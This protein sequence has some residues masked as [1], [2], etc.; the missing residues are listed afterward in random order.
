MEHAEKDGLTPPGRARSNVRTIGSNIVS[1]LTSDV[2]NRATPFFLYALVARYLSTFEFGQISLA[3]LL[4]YTFQVFAVAGLRTLITREVARD[5]TKT[6]KYLINGSIAVFASS[7]LSIIT[8][9]LFVWLM[10]YSADTA[11]AILLLAL[12]LVPYA[13]SN[14]CE[15]VFQAW[16]RMHYIAY[17]NAPSNIAKV[18]LTFL[19][20]TQGYGIYHLA[21]LLVLSYVVVLSIE[22]WLVLRYLTRPQAKLEPRFAL[23][24]VRET[25]PF[26]GIDSAIAIW[27]SL[28]V[29]LLSKMRNETDVGL[30]N[31]ASQLLVPSHLVFQ[32]LVLS[33]FPI[34]CRKFDSGLQNLKQIYEYL[35][36][37]LLAIALPAAVG[38]FFLAEPIL[39][40]LYGDQSFLHAAGVLRIMAWVLIPIALTRALGQVL[41]ASLREKVTLRIVIINTVISL[42]LG[43][44]LIKPFGIMGA[45]I[46]ALV[47]RI[48]DFFQHYVPVS[49]LLSDIAL[50]KVVWKSAVASLCMAV[51]LSVIGNSQGLWLTIP[52]AGLVYVSVL[53]VVL[54][55][56]NKG[57][58]QFK[59]RY[60]YLWSE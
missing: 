22:W 23:A 51:Y 55:W 49:R 2:L 12:G 26:L 45:A 39:L 53:I 1:I 6:D 54:I 46:A 42:V 25:M 8:Q 19:L 58:R 28:N 17:A 43:L 11:T 32:S 29:L 10:G 56:S 59:A 15:A 38:L 13:L 52:T 7:L 37:L 50:G 24:M 3:L 33:I 27:S 57:I 41:L 18:T 35:I 14:I 48:I 44:I 60:L 47:S 34:M 16:E 9:V 21:V 30:Y 4:S 31:A 36:E 40:L 5:R 20:L